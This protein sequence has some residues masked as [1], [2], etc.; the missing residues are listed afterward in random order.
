[1]GGAQPLAGVLAGCSVL[2]VE[3]RSDRIERRI[4]TGYL[5]RRAQSLD[6]GIHLISEAC[7]L[8]EAIS[9]GVLGN[10]VEVYEEILRR[11]LLPN[12]VTDQ[13]AAHDPVNGFLPA[14]WTLNDWEQ[15]REHDPELVARAAKQ[16]M[17][18]HVRTMLE[19]RAL[20]VPVFDY[21]NN[22]RQMAKDAGV[23]DAF[24][25]PGFIAQYIRPQFCRGRAQFRLDCTFWRY[26]RY[27]SNWREAEGSNAE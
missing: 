1:M 12:L 14:D 9:V 18:R 20:G 23:E 4:Y 24:S 21:G 10:A 5:D 2:V 11:G 13:T 17:G 22:I 3:C 19:F 6:E 25:Y 26:R 27:F 16:S 8:G 7:K 15:Q